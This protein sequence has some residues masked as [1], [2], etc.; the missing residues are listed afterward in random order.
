M[1][2]EQ[3][4]FIAYCTAGSPR[5]YN[6]VLS[7]CTNGR[8]TLSRFGA[9]Q[10]KVRPAG[11]RRAQS[12]PCNSRP[13]ERPPCDPTT[14][15]VLPSTDICTV[16][17]PNTCDSMACPIEFTAGRHAAFGRVFFFGSVT[18]DFGPL[19]SSYCKG[20]WGRILQQSLAPSGRKGISRP[21]VS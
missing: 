15:R 17:S 21:A 5:P 4:S 13:T 2:G 16:L 7:S 19:N 8:V 20:Q 3:R 18:M 6:G 1:F 14:N 12:T 10:D 9:F 11:T